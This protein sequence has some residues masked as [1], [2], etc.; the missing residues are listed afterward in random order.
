MILLAIFTVYMNIPVLSIIPD[1]SSVLICHV[2]GHY[3]D[4]LC[5]YEVK[6]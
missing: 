2:L 3:H 5:V 1:T 4:Y 6:K